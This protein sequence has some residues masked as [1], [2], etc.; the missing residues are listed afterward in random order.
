MDVDELFLQYN[1]TC[2]I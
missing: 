1:P 2:W